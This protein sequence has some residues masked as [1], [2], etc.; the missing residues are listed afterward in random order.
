M[1]RATRARRAVA[2]CVFACLVGSGCASTVTGRPTDTDGTPMTSSSP[3]EPLVK[4]PLADRPRSAD[5]SATFNQMQVE[6]RAAV[7]TV[8]PAVSWAP[9]REPGASG[10]S[11]DLVGKGGRT[12]FLQPW[13]AQIPI[14]DEQWPAVVDAVDAAIAPYKFGPLAP[15]VDRAGDHTSE[16]IGPYGATVEIGS[17]N[18]V[19][20]SVIT[21]CH[22]E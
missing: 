17:G 14:P 11:G 19:I 6:I 4:T 22:P 10:C 13:G 2:T 3:K 5:I 20:L 21:G 8:V 12:A 9:R 7:T 16:A 1:N 18:H 15:I